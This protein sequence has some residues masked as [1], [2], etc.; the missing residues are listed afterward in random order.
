MVGRE[1]MLGWGFVM[2]TE[3]GKDG[4]SSAI[5]KRDGVDEKVGGH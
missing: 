1:S 3:P 5:K 2:I 4:A